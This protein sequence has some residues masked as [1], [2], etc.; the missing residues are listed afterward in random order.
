MNDHDLLIRIDQM[1]Q[2]LS[3]RIACLEKKVDSLRLWK[4][5]VLGIAVGVSASISILLNWLI[6]K[7]F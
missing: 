1:L 7:V 3:P 2:D 5:R 4:S 6:K